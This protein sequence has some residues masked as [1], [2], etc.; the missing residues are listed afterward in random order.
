MSTETIDIN[1]LPH[2]RDLANIET[3][4]KVF[5]GPGAGKTTWLAKHLK[6][7]LLESKRLNKTN[8]IACIT[9]TNV[10][11]E[12]L[13][14][15]LKG[16]KS[17]YDISTIHSFLYRNVIKPFSFLI[18]KDDNGNIL[19]DITKLDGHEEHYPLRGNLY[20]WV[21]DI[22]N[23]KTQYGYLLGE[24][25]TDTV[26]CLSDLD[27]TFSNNTLD[28]HFF[29]E[30]A[31]TLAR[32]IQL[33]TTKMFSYKR[34]C[35][36]KGYLYH[37]DVLYFAHYIISRYPKVLEFI[38][39]KFPYIF[40]DEFQDTTEIQTWI[41]DKISEKD[42]TIGVVGDM[43]QSIYKFAG[44]NRNDFI[45]F[46]ANK[47]KKFKLDQNHRSTHK[48]VDFLNLLRSDIKQN[49]GN[50]NEG[51]NVVLLVGGVNK[52]VEWCKNKYSLSELHIIT[53]ANSDVL[54]INNGVLNG[55]EKLLEEMYKADSNSKRARFVNSLMESI[56]YYDKL[57]FKD[58]L[59]VILKEI[60]RS[61]SSFYKSNIKAR[62]VA[63]FILFYIR[64]QENMTRPIKDVYN[65]LHLNLLSN[66]NYSIESRI[67]RGNCSIFYSKYSFNDILPEVKV[68]TKSDDLI[69][70]IHS[71]KGTEF[72]N[73][74]I[75]F[76]DKA[77][78]KKYIINSQNYI[79]ASDD[80]GRIYYVG[81]SRAMKRLII[82]VPNIEGIDIQKIKRMG[83]EIEEVN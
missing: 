28:P 50:C 71:T 18:N 10:A 65:E 38:R 27:W 53:R 40:V 48:I 56:K 32:T 59:N 3:S 73:V 19:F 44:A 69:R 20:S 17:R 2:V 39:Q 7:V 51:E 15:K 4:F 78:F 12:E 24:K 5:A 36:E 43:A 83:F 34:K 68:D 21:K 60:K 31:R 80:D 58:S 57:Y 47:L 35:W 77:D 64:N 26:K 72:D 25:Y 66:Y 9:Y 8:K 14:K 22:S 46:K 29:N 55:K 13:Y 74:L 54:L 1:A 81:C 45:T 61:N 37:E 70:T 30:S 6:R 76:K 63:L 82:N 49:Y 23:S 42:V 62:R 11:T 52:A 41:L 67:T 16:D 75:H 79:D 33:P